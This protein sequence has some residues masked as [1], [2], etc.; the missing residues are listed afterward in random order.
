MW[1]WWE[2]VKTFELLWFVFYQ[3]DVEKNPVGGSEQWETRMKT[4]AEETENL[5]RTLF[6][7]SVYSRVTRCKPA[8]E[9]SCVLWISSACLLERGSD[10]I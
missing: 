4:E 2:K 3:E 7:G 9:M 1:G 6:P 5:C 10:F 8:F